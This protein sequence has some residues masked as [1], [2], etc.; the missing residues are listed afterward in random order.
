[1]SDNIKENSKNNKENNK[2]NSKDISILTKKFQYKTNGIVK[3]HEVDAFQVV[4]NLQY[5]LWSEV[6]RVEYCKELGINIFPDIISSNKSGITPPF[7]I[8]LVHSDVNYY[9]PATFGD[10]YC[11]Y[12]RI[13]KLGN[14][15]LTFEHIITKIEISN[16]N[17]AETLLCINHA[18]EV[19]VDANRQPMRIIDDIRNK[20][21]NFEKENVEINAKK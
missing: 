3:F 14:S 13:S 5:L 12:T 1:M 8:F 6:A 16:E 18:V 17:I 19:Y 9:S 11:V 20:I 4:H 10:A 2:E 21:L 7:S 15:S